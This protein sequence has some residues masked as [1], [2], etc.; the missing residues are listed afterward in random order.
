MGIYAVWDFLGMMSLE[1]SGSSFCGIV[2]YWK[3]SKI[4]MQEQRHLITLEHCQK[5]TILS[6]YDKNTE[7]WRL[8]KIEDLDVEQT[9]RGL[10][11]N[12]SEEK[13]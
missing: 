1:N 6:V 2:Y 7:E 9:Y 4:I 3:S 5:K 11:L 13:D 8:V 12:E 10:I